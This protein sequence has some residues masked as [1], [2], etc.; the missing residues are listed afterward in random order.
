[1]NGVSQSFS[2]SFKSVNRGQAGFAAIAITIALALAA[3]AALA[4]D[5]DP[6]GFGIADYTILSRDL[7]TVLGHTRYSVTPDGSTLVLRGDNR[8]LNGEYDHETDRLRVHA[9]GAVPALVSYEHAYFDRTGSPTRTTRADFTTGD[10]E[11]LT[12]TPGGV[13]ETV[14]DHFDFPPDTYAGAS[15]L[16]RIEY[17]LRA[18]SSATLRIHAYSCV[19]GPRL[20]TLEVTP[21]AGV[22]WDLYSRE[23]LAVDARPTLGWWDVV[24]VPFLPKLRAWFDPADRFSFL[25]GS[26][27]RYYR[28]PWVEL[29]REP[30]SRSGEARGAAPSK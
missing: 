8:F 2:Q 11:C 25:G 12:Y 14:V 3:N 23:A 1:M 16:I 29:L 4:E 15:L 22:R 18:D 28:G 7:T 5:R 27:Q 9:P 13:V 10:A 17:A 24:L 6:L 20:I 30:N 21:R 19:P 26:T